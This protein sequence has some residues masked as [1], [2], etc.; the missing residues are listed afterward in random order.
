MAAVNPLPQPILTAEKQSELAQIVQGMSRE[1][2]MWSSGFLAGLASAQLET[3]VQTESVPSEAVTILFASQTGNGKRVAEK[4]AGQLEEKGANVHLVDFAD[5]RK[6]QL[7]KETQLFAVI[8]THG[9]GDPPDSAEPLF[10]FLASKRAPKLENL[11]YSVLAL[12][13]SSY[14]YYCEAGRKFDERLAELGAQ[15]L[16]DRVDCDVDFADAAA[17][18]QAD[19]LDRVEIR[20]DGPSN[21]INLPKRIRSEFHRDNPYRAEILEVQAITSRESQSHTIHVELDLGESQLTYEP[22]DA[23]GV[24]PINNEVLVEA[25][26]AASGLS[27]DEEVHIGQD[28]LTLR[29]ALAEHREINQISAATFTRWAAAG[30]PDAQ[31]AYEAMEPPQ[32]RELLNSWVLADFVAR[33]GAPTDPQSLV[34]A[35]PAM[36]PRLYSIASSPITAEGE[37]HLTVARLE[38][39]HEGESRFGAATRYLEDLAPGDSARVYVEPNTSFRLPDDP[40]APIIMVGAGTGVAPFRAFVDHRVEEGAPGS[41]WLIFGHRH[42]RS[43]FLYQ[44]EWLRHH[45]EG[46]LARLDVAFSRDQDEKRYVQHLVA[47]NAEEIGE[48]LRAGGHFYVCG[49]IAMGQAVEAALVDTLGEAFVDTIKEEKRWHRDV[50]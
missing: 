37:V 21:V 46:N 28:T 48:Q 18:W 24:Y 7:A 17:T 29:E 40:N 11:R 43:D 27:G 30:L 2:L 50:Y 15:R 31:A 25:V 49:S 23:L 34:D 19:V 16:L 4:L 1:Q 26:L 10:K 44:I 5:Y 6:Q 20:E 35:L 45:K 32:R 41:N 12:G 42:L 3:L 38:W 14:E 9:E 13:D 39:E 47:E 33:Y 36:E 8:S 22:G